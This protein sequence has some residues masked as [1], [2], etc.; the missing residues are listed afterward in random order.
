MMWVSLIV[1]ALLLTTVISTSGWLRFRRRLADSTRERTDLANSSLVVEEERRMLELV[2]QGAPLGE[3]LN[4]LTLAIERLSPGALCT[5]MLLDE[6]HRQ[7]LTAAS[8]PSLAPEYLQAVNGLEIGPQV[9]A[10]GTAAF[11]NETVVVA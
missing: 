10:C 4:T 3:V 6:E 5:V 11:L 8:G 1:A 2:A 9:G 7:Y